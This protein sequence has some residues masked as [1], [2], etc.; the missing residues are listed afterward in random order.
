[1]TKQKRKRPKTY[2]LEEVVRA[3]NHWSMTTV[4]EEE[5]KTFINKEQKDDKQLSFFEH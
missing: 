2:T 1:M 5:I 3:V 4:P